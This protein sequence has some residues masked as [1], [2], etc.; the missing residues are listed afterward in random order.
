MGGTLSCTGKGY[1][2][3]GEGRPEPYLPATKSQINGSVVKP[4]GT[5]LPLEKDTT[6]EPD[7][8]WKF[9]QR[10]TLR[11]SDRKSKSKKELKYQERNS[12]IPEEGKRSL[13]GL[14]DVV[15]Q[16]VFRRSNSLKPPP[17]PPR[18]FLF[19]SST[20][21]TPRSSVTGENDRNSFVFSQ[22]YQR[23][24][25]SLDLTKQA[26]LENDPNKN[27]TGAIA[28][29][30]VVSSVDLTSKCPIGADI[31]NNN[32]KSEN[33]IKA[34]TQIVAEVKHAETSNV[35]RRTPTGKI[36]IITPD[37]SS[38]RAIN[39]SKL[40][41][42]DICFS[43]RHI[44]ILQSAYELLCQK[45]DPFVILDNLR[46][47]NILTDTDLIAFRGHPDKRLVCESIIQT[48][49]DS[50]YSVFLSFTEVLR[51]CEEYIR[52]AFILDAM[53][54][55]YNLIYEIQCESVQGSPLLEDETSVTFDVVYYNEDTGRVRSVVELERSRHSDNKRFSRDIINYKRS[56][57]LSFYS[58]ASELSLNSSD[59]I[60]N[61]G[62]P[63]LTVSISGHSLQGEKAQALKDLL[64]KHLCILE[65]HLGKTHLRGE[66]MRHIAS[67]LQG[68]VGITVLDVRLNSINNDGAE[69]LASVL[70]TNKTIRQL[71][72]S[73]TG[74]DSKGCKTLAEALKTNACLIELDM[75]FLDIG[76]DGCVAL[77]NMLKLNRVLRKLRL[78]SDNISWIGCGFLFEGIQ[79]GKC[80]TELDLSRNFI[81]DDGVEMISRHLD[82]ISSLIELNLENCG[83]TSSGCALISD[84]IM[85]NKSLTNMDL[86]VNFIGDQGLAKLS[87]ALERN[88]HIKTLGLNMCG[89]T[90]DGFSKLLDILEINPTLTL[91]KLCYNRLGR[92]HNNPAATSDDLRYR[93]RIVTSSNP[94]L[95][96]LL[97]G[98]SFEDSMQ[99]TSVS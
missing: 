78:R 53:T 77:G 18:L 81:G 22:A 25:K 54:D 23:G 17:K 83:L 39:R 74:I 62:V 98:N 85:R 87:T 61:T 79:Q 41:A 50:D 46:K 16:S 91:L 52:I 24:S 89:I 1:P 36:K 70:E 66:D 80:I 7:H 86:S 19:R 14:P 21:N 56:S 20:I 28:N 15:D 95:K 84:V 33:N 10:L 59:D 2:T 4:R 31:E 65:L 5:D 97:W 42:G 92:E 75:S 88:R 68:K 73:S 34:E 90:N 40:K 26:I 60:M 58:M 35:P 43:E 99:T 6:S 38:R 47:T 30:Q 8:S 63:M 94:K 71:N 9:W 49:M 76:D 51:N 55:L 29:G 67:A 13:E 82:D 37:L 3:L 12:T 69:V 72:I 44:T 45:M 64:P 93:V 57:R 11:R 27:I 96:I 48:V 32:L